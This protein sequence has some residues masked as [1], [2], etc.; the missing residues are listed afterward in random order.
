MATVQYDPKLV[1]RYQFARYVPIGF[2]DNRLGLTSSL[3]ADFDIQIAS[4]S[5]SFPSSRLSTHTNPPPPSPPAILYYDY[6]L[7]LPAELK[8]IWTQP[9]K[10]STYF[11]LFCRYSLLANLLWLL[12]K[13]GRP[14]VAAAGWD[15]QEKGLSCNTVAKSAGALALF[16][17]IGVLGGCISNLRCVEEGHADDLV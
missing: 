11:Y 5:R 13:A 10:P 2:I 8:F 17:H 6:L 16:G 1:R 3:S 12:E 9:K 7:T 4:I 15:L 14:E